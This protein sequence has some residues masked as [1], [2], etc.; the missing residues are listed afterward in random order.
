M[1][2]L[3]PDWEGQ[4]AF[5]AVLETGSLSGAARRLSLAQPTVRRR[6]ED[7]ERSL[8][9]ALFTRSP[10]G[11]TPTPAALLL[12][13]HARAMASAAAAFT[14]A[15]SAEA[16][17]QAGTVRITASEIVA[18]EVLPA[19]LADLQER[20]PGLEIELG[21]S[22][23]NEDLMRREA[24]IAVRMSPP[25]QEALLVR[26]IG[27]VP[28]G[29]FAHRRLVERF[30]LP[31]TLE[32]L[33]AMPFVGFEHP[34][35]YLERMVAGGFALSLVD[36]SFRSDNDL[37]QLAAIRA[38]VGAGACQIALGRRCPDL[39]PMLTGEF[40]YPLETWVVMHEDL[41]GLRRMRLVFDA[42][43]EGMAAYVRAT[44]K[45]GAVARTA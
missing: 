20:H 10:A 5:L 17:A 28:L 11:L 23:R 35:P 45:V 27:E 24:D 34:P 37:A 4:R 16:Q 40:R 14:R 13:E 7:L 21:A 31:R 9:A 2:P 42:L 36:F 26:R 22:N 1:S 30:G 33:R 43:V 29:L 32:D 44:E 3:E 15:A 41:K 18:V 25:R 8:G 6:I 19:I 38:G 12:G 39:V